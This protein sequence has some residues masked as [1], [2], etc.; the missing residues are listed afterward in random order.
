MI[1]KI[2]FKGKTLFDI[3]KTQIEKDRLLVQIFNNGNGEF[4]VH[5]GD[6]KDFNSPHKI[7]VI[8]PFGE[9]RGFNTDKIRNHFGRVNPKIYAHCYELS[10]SEN[11]ETI[12]IGKMIREVQKEIMEETQYWQQT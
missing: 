7:D 2:I 10:N 5:C 8:I 12:N 1:A 11:K 3:E 6:K 4:V 9:I